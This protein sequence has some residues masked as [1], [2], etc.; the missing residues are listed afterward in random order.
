MGFD[1]GRRGKRK[2]LPRLRKRRTTS[3]FTIY[4]GSYDTGSGSANKFRGTTRNIAPVFLHSL[5]TC[6]VLL[7]VV[8]FQARGATERVQSAP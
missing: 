3:C 7:L 2:R 1:G 6:L 8:G 4:V 5:T